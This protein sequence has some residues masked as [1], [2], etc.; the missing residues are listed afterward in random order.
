M[1]ESFEKSLKKLGFKEALF[2]AYKT[3]SQKQKEK[4]YRALISYLLD[5]HEDNLRRQNPQ[6]HTKENRKRQTRENITTNG[7]LGLQHSFYDSLFKNS[8][9]SR[10][11]LNNFKKYIDN[12]EVFNSFINVL[13]DYLKDS[14]NVPYKSKNS[15]DLKI[16]DKSKLI[17]RYTTKYE[18]ENIFNRY[19]ELNKIISGEIKDSDL[20]EEEARKEKISIAQETAKSR[21]DPDWQKI[22]TEKKADEYIEK[23]KAGFFKEA[24]TEDED[25]FIFK[26]TEERY[27]FS[28]ELLNFLERANKIIKLETDENEILRQLI[29]LSK[30][31][32]FDSIFPIA[33]EL[34]DMLRREINDIEKSDDE[35]AKKNIPYYKKIADHSQELMEQGF[36]D[37]FFVRANE[38]I[39]KSKLSNR[40]K[41][42]SNE[43]A[44]TA[45]KNLIKN[46]F[47]TKIILPIKDDKKYYKKLKNQARDLNQE[48]NLITLKRRINT[49]EENTLEGKIRKERDKK[50]TTLPMEKGKELL[51][52]KR[53]FRSFLNALQPSDENL[54][55]KIRMFRDLGD[56]NIQT[57]KINELKKELSILPYDKSDDTYYGVYT[58][59]EK[60]RQILNVLYSI[61]S[62][63]KEAGENTNSK[64]VD[65]N[66]LPTIDKNSGYV[67]F[68]VP[69]MKNY[70]K[71][72][73]HNGFENVSGNVWDETK[74]SFRPFIEVMKD[75][76]P[77]NMYEYVKYRPISNTFSLDTSDDTGKVLKSGLDYKSKFFKDFDGYT[78]A[79]YDEDKNL[80][81]PEQY[82]EAK[83]VRKLD[84]N[85]NPEDLRYIKKWRRDEF[86]RRIKERRKNRHN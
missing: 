38:L 70:D 26:E 46:W 34:S 77:R 43:L 22:D 67:R 11:K 42:K 80:L 19:N 76:Y 1:T 16:N 56:T 30:N 63:S 23:I 83:F 65:K 60:I 14:L 47:I 3:Q 15:K 78:L 24:E 2:D 45:E 21:K 53:Q 64:T 37:Y 73:L 62:V 12:D 86:E 6:T 31:Y 84:I 13:K 66:K 7:E 79:L 9:F 28:E 52:L 41:N 4:K 17:Q 20:D 58:N 49:R 57:S 10:N 39:Q 69:K 75:R 50:S 18:T 59:N 85:N 82:M 54:K 25:E 36:T 81:R 51:A 48:I 32:R 8:V 71:I 55:E 61:F 72:D 5:I 44:K 40:I 35:E 27:Q 68:I 33:N 74:K 29:A